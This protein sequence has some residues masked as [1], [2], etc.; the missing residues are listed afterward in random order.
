M[1]SAPVFLVVLGL[2]VL[3]SPLGCSRE[4][5]DGSQETGPATTESPGSGAATV[6][7]AAGRTPDPVPA[8]VAATPGNRVQFVDA[9]AASGLDF[10]LVSG[11]PQQ[12]YI[13]A[14]MAGGVAFLDY[15]NDG[16]LDVFMVSSSRMEDPPAGAFN[17][18]YKNVAGN[19]GGR[20]FRD[21][22]EGSGLQR[23]GWGMG[24]AAGDY[25][26]D[27]DVDIY[28]T[29]VGPNALYRN[30]GDGTFASV[31]RRAGV[32]DERWGASAAFADLD[33][34]GYLDLYV[35]NY[36]V[37]D[38]ESP[39]QP[40]RGWKGL[41]VFY[42]PDGMDTVPDALYRNNGDG[43]FSDLSARTG[44]NRHYL[45]GLGVVF[46]DYDNDGDQDIY[47]ANDGLPNLLFRNE[48]DWRLTE[49][50]TPAEVAYSDDGRAQAGMGTTFGDY[51]DDGDADLF[52]TNY[53][54]DV[55]TLYQ[56]QGDGF[57]ID[58][59]FA[60]GLGGE[61][62]PYLSWS[63]NFFDYDNDRDLDLF[64]VNG[65]LFPQLLDH[66]SGLRYPQRNLLYA[67]EGGR[68]RSVGESA[69]PGLAIEKVSRGG[70]FG[71]YDNDGDVDL[72]ITNLNDTPDLL[73]NEGGN[74]NNWIGLDLVGTTSNRDAIG[75]RVQLFAGGQ[76]QT[77]EVRRAYGYQSQHDPRLV[78][79]LGTLTEV[80]RVEI[81]WPGGRIRTLR[82]LPLR[83]YLVVKEGE[84]GIA[85]SYAAPANSPGAAVATAPPA[86]E[87]PVGTDRSSYPED[88][89]WTAEEYYLQGEKFYASGRYGEAMA[90]FAEAVRLQ[91]D[92]F[93]A[94]RV[95]G[96]TLIKGLGDYQ[97]AVE[98]LQ[99]VVRRDSTRAEL[100]DL[101]AMAY[102]G[103]DQP[104]A[105]VKAL[106]RATGLDT[107]AWKYYNLLGRAHLRRGDLAAATA[108]LQ[109]A[110]RIAPSATDPH[111]HLSR[112]YE[113]QG[114][115]RDARQE[116]HRFRTLK[117]EHKQ[118][119]PYLRRL[120]E[121]PDDAEALYS[122]AVGYT[123]QRRYEAALKCFQRLAELTPGRGMVH[124]GLGIAYHNLGKLEEAI[125]A[126]NQA[127]QLDS[128]LSLVFN[129]LGRAYQQLGRLDEALAAYRR[130]IR[131]KPDFALVR[132][133]LGEVYALQG[134][135]QQAIEAYK[136][137]LAL[138][139]T[140]TESRA[141]LARLYADAGL[142][143]EAIREW[144]IVLQQDPGHPTAAT[145]LQ[146]AKQRLSSR[147]GG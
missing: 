6:E 42:G 1:G 77:R 19:D 141:A 123:R 132:S 49:V 52:V 40:R 8:E 131:L 17:R 128:R 24:C 121:H 59:T 58:A 70:A 69:G 138:E 47:V 137:A 48:G 82:D 130:L 67:N 129:D 109:R 66:P 136:E 134:K 25:D 60:L 56:N 144:Q 27:G 101:I 108:S 18:L 3:T 116:R 133:N 35:A 73:R 5:G 140:L 32:A 96:A 34:D 62:Q 120:E 22:T 79:G 29:Y 54:D 78:F 43:T 113:R 93:Q 94:Y 46:G 90:M 115:R 83:R 31:G 89:T 74:H 75:A 106:E 105:A 84:A 119:E 95:W 36:L 44:M 145:L 15:D 87:R 146:Q 103:L 11:S 14:A 127:Y 20:V 97:G 65:H 107:T 63:T 7:P 111:L 122:L 4:S 99:P 147:G 38:P 23:A 124:Y 51:D 112:V 37:F 92:Y 91:P 28:V 98:L 21:V 135:R 125:A 68:F 57:F 72:L 45:P 33:A 50:G 71:D 16:Y 142:L 81:R 126:Y 55:N 117:R 53:S 39:P 2:I 86:L 61:A 118:L 104:E 9:S 100:Y 143:R 139:S 12:D 64:V 114:R 10:T 110:T 13:V 30:N 88:P 26:N 85:D 102:M 41:V 80:D 76:T